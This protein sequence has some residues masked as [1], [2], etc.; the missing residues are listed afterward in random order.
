MHPH[1]RVEGGK[2]KQVEQQCIECN[3]AVVLSGKV[4]M[5]HS[6]SD[7]HVLTSSYSGQ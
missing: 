1:V 6:R 2:N 5:V 7:G 3:T 4:V